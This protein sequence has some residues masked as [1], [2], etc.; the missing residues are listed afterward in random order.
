[1]FHSSNLESCILLFSL[2]NEN[3]NLKSKQLK[4][5]ID[6]K[7]LL[8]TQFIIHNHN[9]FMESNMMLTSIDNKLIEDARLKNY[10][11][12]ALNIKHM[13]IMNTEI[14]ITELE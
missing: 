11:Q 9:W 12:I 14:E 1:M 8:I 10:E 6:R 3:S 2:N 4:P 7:L 13:Q 5:Y